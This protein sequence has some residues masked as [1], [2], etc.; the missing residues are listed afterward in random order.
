[1]L[2]DDSVDFMVQK[3]YPNPQTSIIR[4]VEL[5]RQT[6]HV[7]S[8]DEAGPTTEGMRIVIAVC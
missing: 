4:H 5:T 3:K 6:G 1:M 8:A 7:A 2:A